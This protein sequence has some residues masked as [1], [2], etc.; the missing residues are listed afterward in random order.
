MPSLLI[1]SLGLSKPFW[2]WNWNIY[3]VLV[4]YSDWCARHDMLQVWVYGYEVLIH[5][6]LDKSFWLI[7]ACT[8]VS[9]R[10]NLCAWKREWER[11][12]ERLTRHTACPHTTITA[13]KAHCK[14]KLMLPHKTKDFLFTKIQKLSCSTTR[15]E[16]VLHL[17][18]LLDLK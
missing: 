13:V 15:L 3:F 10:V 11:E 5:P 9:E 7:L 16:H 12:R 1:L 4:L 6:P 2:S 17:K 8:R 14:D 18:R